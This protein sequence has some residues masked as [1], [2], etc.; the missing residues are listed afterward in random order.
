[1]SKNERT[2]TDAELAH[3]REHGYV[4]IEDFFPA[5]WNLERMDEL[6][7]RPPER[8]GEREAA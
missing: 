2:L 3:Y 6:A 4:A 7:G 5:G 1:M 8:I